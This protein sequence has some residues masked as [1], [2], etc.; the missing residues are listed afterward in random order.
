MQRGKLEGFRHILAWHVARQRADEVADLFQLLLERRQ[1]LLDL[2]QGDLLR[3]NIHVRH[4]AGLPLMLERVQRPRAGRDYFFSGGN[5]VT[6]RGF[7]NG[8]ADHTGFERDVSR[9]QFVTLHRC[10]RFQAFHLPPIFTKHVNRVTD[11]HLRRVK[12]IIDRGVKWL[13][14]WILIS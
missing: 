7:L 12:S 5:L 2:G 11:R 9:V 6:R 10:L 8:R 14:V 1:R 4:I 13:P 3:G